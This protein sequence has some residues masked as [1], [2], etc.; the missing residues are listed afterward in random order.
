MDTNTSIPKYHISVLMD[1]SRAS[2]IALTNAVQLAKTLNGR[3]EAFFAKA[4]VDVVKFDN[5][6]SAMRAIHEDNRKSKNRLDKMIKAISEQENLPISFKIGHGN[7]K[8]AVRSYVNAQKPDILVL[9][10]RKRSV[11]NL[12]SNGVTDFALNESPAHVLIVGEDD[13]FHSFADLSLGVFGNT[14]EEKGFEIVNDLKRNSCK[15]VRLFNI[16]SDEGIQE[17]ESKL[18]QT[19]SYVFS[20]GANAA[21]GLASYVNRTNT[22]LF[23]VPKR[24][25]KGRSAQTAATKQ[26]LRKLSVPILFMAS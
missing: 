13:K 10:K 20:E 22:Q 8:S 18:K 19:V 6:L 7:V 3:V 23:C 15:P 24:H 4:P 2:Q 11:A 25:R 26:V 1:S 5:Q 12:V 21:D 14:L 16:K 17:L 9:A